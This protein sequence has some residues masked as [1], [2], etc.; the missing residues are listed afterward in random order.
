VELMSRN[1]KALAVQ[2]HLDTPAFKAWFEGSRVTDAQGGPALCTHYTDREFFAFSA[3][4]QKRAKAEGS[5]YTTSFGLGYVFPETGFFFFVEDAP[6]PV[7]KKT[8]VVTAHL[9]IKNP[10]D[11]TRRISAED[12][13]RII[14]FIKV[15]ATLKPSPGHW[16]YT[17]KGDKL[18]GF[19]KARKEGVTAEQLWAF[20]NDNTYTRRGVMWDQMLAMLGKDGVVFEGN[21][22]GTAL[23]EAERGAG[24]GRAYRIAV[25][26]DPTQIKSATNAGTYDPESP[27]MR[28]SCVRRERAR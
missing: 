8:I 10:L 19:R 12:T 20:L 18:G 17:P 16:G 6:L 26:L 13:S 22:S 7:G 3:A 1:P 21:S 27:D 2:S 28:F 4:E 5:G 9:S 14:D 23:L 15:K 25:A 24:D 11:L